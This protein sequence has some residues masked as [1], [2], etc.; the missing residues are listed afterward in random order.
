M[1]AFGFGM[2]IA[3]IVCFAAPLFVGKGKRDG[4]T[5]WDKKM[6][7]AGFRQKFINGKWYWV[8]KNEY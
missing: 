7:E 8:P 2:L 4:H 5:D 6:E 3:I 1:E